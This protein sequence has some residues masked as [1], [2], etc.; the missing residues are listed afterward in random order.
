MTKNKIIYILGVAVLMSSCKKD[1][2]PSTTPD[3]NLG[4]VSFTNANASSKTLNVV[5]DGTQINST[6]LAVNSTFTGV[7][8]GFSDGPHALVTK[9][10]GVTPAVDVFSGNISVSMGKSYSFFQ[11][12]VLTGGVFKGVLLNTDRTPDANADNS[13]VRFL[14][15]SNGAPALDFVMV[16]QEGTTPK[17]SVILFSGVPSLATVTTP[18]IAALSVQKAVAGN[19]AANAIPGVAVSSYIIR[20]KL[21][22]TNTIVSSTAA[23]TIVPGRNY[24]FYAR[25]N[26]P[27]S[28][29]SSLL[30]N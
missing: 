8:A 1:K 26:Y 19:K 27:S 24:T 6:A 30:D 16:R 20:L 12:G 22:S 11:Y 21:A 13:K 4:Y 5:V 29:L 3:T 10:A 18:D 23:T 9:D 17:D 14:N 28:V 7:Y 25:G 15:L 2:A